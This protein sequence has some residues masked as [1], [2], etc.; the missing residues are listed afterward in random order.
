MSDFKITGNASPVVGKE[1]FYTISNPLTSLFPH[2]AAPKSPF[3]TPV[4]WTVHVLEYGRWRK[5]KENDKKGDKVSYTFLQ[6]SLQRDGIRIMATKGDQIARIDVKP[7]S[8]DKPKINNIELLDKS[9]KK[10]SA[11]LSYGQTL[12]ARV[13][14]LHMEKRKVYVTLW[15]DDAAGAGHN[16]A[17]EKN[18]LDTRSG[19]VKDGIVDIDFLLKPSFAKIAK[20]SKDEGKIHEYYVTT[21]FDNEKLAS[22]N[23]NV[24]DLETPV[25]PY[26]GKT[27]APP[28]QP[29]KTAAPTQPV[30][31]KTS[32][33][34]GATPPKGQIT[35]VHITDTADRPITGIFKEKQLKVWIDSKEL[36]GKEVRLRLYDHDNGSPNDLLADLKFPIRAN[37]HAMV[38]RLDTIPRSLGGNLFQEGA[39]Q[40][41][42]AEVEVFQTKTSSINEIVKVDAKVFKQDQG[43][44]VNTVMKIFQPSAEDKK[45]DEKGECERCKILTKDELKLI[46][47]DASDTML[48]DVISAFNDGAKLFEVNTCLRK[49]HFFAQVLKEVGT[50]LELKKPESMNYSAGALKDGYW[51]STGTNWVK[52]NLETGEGGYFR[53]GTK[54]NFCNLSYFR[55]NNHIADLYGRKDLNSYSDKGVQK[56]NEDMLANYAYSNQYGNGGFETGD[57]S[58]YRGK[59]LIQLTWKENYEKVYEKIKVVDASVN[60]VTNPDKILTNIRYAVFSAMGFW[61]LKKINDVIGND[62]NE[63]IANLVTG[64][65]NPNDDAD[66]KKRRREN[67]K[68]ITKTVFKVDECKNGKSSEKGVEGQ[69]EYYT[70]K[71]GKIK[72][73]KGS[74]KKHAYYVEKDGGKFK[75]LYVLDENEHGMVKIPS[76]GSGFGRYSGVDA[77]GV[78]GGETVGQGDHY[79][80]PKTAAGLFGIISEVNEKG[81]EIHLGD[82]SSENGSD[83]WG[84]GSSHHAGHGHLGTRKGLDCDFRYLNTS[85]KSYQGNNT[86][87][88]FDKDKNK[89]F[90]N[91]AH[92]YGFRKNFCANPR[93]I[94]GDSVPGVT[95][96]RDHADHGHIG[97]T[98]LDLEEVSSL[99]VNK[100]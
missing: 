87:S 36:I 65:I 67:Y 74:V 42:F 100:I 69:S 7:Q 45:K 25:A 92:T 52:G 30:K 94:F 85:G 53:N 72:L 77:G 29:V 12:K 17:N 73:I 82:M 23:V 86:D 33:S 57:G 47:T 64:K 15:E 60:I 63:S 76:T 49:A 1:E 70:Y 66:A 2:T 44:V 32:P 56:A 4:L 27:T 11:P 31:P 61:Q 62:T 8:A 43:E 81:W 9:G 84:A 6:R 93:T 58:K 28:Q 54:K 14:C 91:L 13:H 24:N 90:F 71:S 68:N 35:K 46:F 22:K 37:I 98:N 20:M 38:I 10:P 83:P 48:T 21:D 50:K 55:T 59:G 5:T 78:S 34:S 16:K 19:I 3:D 79:L 80:L 99:N 26:K 97:L 96:D 89:A 95:H 88:V 40:E 51:Y 41:L 18:L 39:E 75:L